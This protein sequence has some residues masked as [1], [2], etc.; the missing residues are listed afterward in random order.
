MIFK[1]GWHVIYVR[2]RWEKRVHESMQE[3]SLDSFLPLVKERRQWADRKKTV[4][5]PMFRSYVFVNINSSLEFYKA[6]SVH[7]ACSYIRFGNE[8]ARVTEKEINQIKILIGDKNITD[9]E[10]NTRLPKVGEIKN[11]TYGLLS[12]LDCEI[13]RVDSQDKIVVRL[14]SLRLNVTANVSANC[15]EN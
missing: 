3:I 2:S 7:G 1:I 10:V 15:F 5:R 12:G 11:I 8:Y 14:D 9:I 4:L 13:V 6:L